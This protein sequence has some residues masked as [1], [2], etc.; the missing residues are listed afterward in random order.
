MNQ[1][2]S[3]TIAAEDVSC[4]WGTMGAVGRAPCARSTELIKLG[5]SAR[6]R[7]LRKPL[8]FVFRD[9][10]N[11]LHNVAAGS[12]YQAWRPPGII[13]LSFSTYIARLSGSQPDA[14]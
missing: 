13:N 7:V 6:D 14:A 1:R 4:G 2:E 5:L 12:G 9:E 10:V 3:W 11:S 8:A